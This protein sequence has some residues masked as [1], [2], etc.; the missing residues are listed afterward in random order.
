MECTLPVPSFRPHVSGSSS[1]WAALLLSAL[2]AGCGSDRAA[3]APA[4]EE[5][6]A[7]V[8]IEPRAFPL[9]SSAD[10]RIFRLPLAA[11]RLRVVDV[12]GASFAALRGREHASLVLNAGFF[13]PAFAPEGLVVSEGVVRS[14]HVE[15]LSGGVVTVEHARASLLPTEGFV[16]GPG[17][18]FAIQCRPR[19]VVDGAV[20]IASETGRR[21]AR[22][23]LCLR[24]GG[25]TLDVVIAPAS[26]GAGPTLLE[27]AVALAADGCEGALNLDGGPSTGAAWWSTDGAHAIEPF[28]PV[29]Q[30]IVVELAP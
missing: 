23:A 19:L 9:P 16:L 21:A 6:P 7:P 27:L 17:T 8:G 14:A 11:A 24:D 1:A 18:D 12:D 28:G 2:I 25:A 3:R 5:A 4:P 15:R 22:T 26:D 20:N 10:A 29:R 30:A 13:D